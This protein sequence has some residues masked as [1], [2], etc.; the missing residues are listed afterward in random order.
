M[1]ADRTWTLPASVGMAVGDVVRVKAPADVGAYKIIISK[2]GSQTIDGYDTVELEA[3]NA[4]L[5]LIYADTDTW[6][7]V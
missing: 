1:T 5:T 6:I 2:A 7:I 3:D 4:A